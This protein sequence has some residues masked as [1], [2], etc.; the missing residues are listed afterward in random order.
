MT[1]R[2]WH[3]SITDL[4]R[5]PGY[6]TALAEHVSTVCEPS[7]SRRGLY[8]RGPDDARQH[9]TEVTARA[10]AVPDSAPLDPGGPA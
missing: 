2:I 3:Q 5:L 7:V 9:I 6:R 1:M 4:T 8:A 10:L